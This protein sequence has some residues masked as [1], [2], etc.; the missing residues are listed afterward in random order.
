MI[1]ICCR[2]QFIIYINAN[3]T[4]NI[5]INISPQ[6]NNR[7]NFKSQ[8]ISSPLIKNSPPKNHPQNKSPRISGF[9]ILKDARPDCAAEGIV[10]VY[11]KL[12]PL[13]GRI[14]GD[15][16]SAAY[17]LV[18][19][20]L[21]EGSRLILPGVGLNP[22][23]TTEPVVPTRLILRGRTTDPVVPTLRLQSRASS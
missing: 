19:A 21:L 8:I 9:I 1:N 13:S 10:P 15:T 14:P 12:G 11:S 20:T 18:A 16:S 3:I 7:L 4:S 2:Q 5:L 23:R 22:T 6:L 17:W